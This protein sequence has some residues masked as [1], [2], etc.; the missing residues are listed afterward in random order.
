M[1][2]CD[3]VI[4]CL[5]TKSLEFWDVNSFEVLDNRSEM[6]VPVYVNWSDASK[7]LGTLGR[8][9]IL[10]IWKILPRYRSTLML[11]HRNS[12]DLSKY[13]ITSFEFLRKGHF[14]V[15][16]VQFPNRFIVFSA[17][18][19]AIQKSCF[20][21]SSNPSIIRCAGN[22]IAAA[23]TINY[24]HR[25]EVF[26]ASQKKMV[27]SS[28]R[29]HRTTGMKWNYAGTQLI[30]SEGGIPKSQL[31]ILLLD[32]KLTEFRKIDAHFGTIRDLE[33]TEQDYFVFTTGQDGLLKLWEGNTLRLLSKTSIT[34]K[35]I[36]S[37]AFL[38]Q[39][40]AS[41]FA[42]SYDRQLSIWDVHPYLELASRY[43]SHREIAATT[44]QQWYCARTYK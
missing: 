10:T 18:S 3:Q 41:L 14:G 1:T 2:L 42:C 19:E 27:A 43:I 40:K 17:N 44:I 23:S 29:P 16:A 33:I 5:T 20:P 35:E 31:I 26:N 25:I 22:L 15:V 4:A 34:H 9:G 12:I 32:K 8:Q 6:N 30:I 39:P 24:L 7:L 37:L 13:K 21:I 38:R 28:H 11:K 36:F